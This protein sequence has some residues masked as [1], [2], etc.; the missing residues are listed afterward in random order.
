MKRG[1][2]ISALSLCVFIVGLS[3]L[4]EPT[5]VAAKTSVTDPLFEREQNDELYKKIKAFQEEHRVAPTDAKIDRI[6]KAIPGY[7]GLEVDIEKSY[8]KMKESGAFDSTK[9][10][11]KEVPPNVHL[12]DLAAEPIYRGNQQKPMAALLIN[13]AWGNEYILPI[14]KALQEADV[15]ATFFYDGSWVKKNP[16]L[17][18]MIYMEGHEIGNHAY[19]HP[20]LQRR[21]KTETYQEI[22]KTNDVIV[23]TIGVRPTWFAPPS[24]S[25]NQTT[26]EVADELEMKT[27]LWTIDTVDWKKPATEEMVNR[28]LKGIDKGYMVLMHPTKPVA[29]GFADMIAGIKAKGL[30]LGTVSEL[31]SEKRI[32]QLKDAQ[33][34]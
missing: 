13:V 17:A 30:Q 6:W 21:S 31:M 32:D 24:G 3:S 1:L 28:I 9:I 25:F 26:I 23:E 34:E 20:D 14:L 15:K 12:N 2:I 11:F 22:D 7:N 19:S 33:Q 18:M 5:V 8:E 10:V 29:E 4:I 27:I 16:E